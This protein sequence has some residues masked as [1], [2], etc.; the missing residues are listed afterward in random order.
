VAFVVRVRPIKASISKR[1]CVL[2]FES[3]NSLE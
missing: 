1:Y 2:L 3:D